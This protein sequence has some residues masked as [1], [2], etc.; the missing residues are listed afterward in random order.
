MMF[1][2]RHTIETPSRRL[3][4]GCE[5][6]RV[7]SPLRV[8]AERDFVAAHAQISVFSFRRN[9]ASHAGMT[10]TRRWPSRDGQRRRQRP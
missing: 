6:A 2:I 10:W 7:L 8:A 5:H 4:T 1:T 9:R 3:P